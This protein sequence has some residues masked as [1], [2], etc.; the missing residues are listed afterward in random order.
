MSKSVLVSSMQCNARIGE[1]IVWK[2][3][4]WAVTTPKL[5][6]VSVLLFSPIHIEL[7]FDVEIVFMSWRSLSQRG[8]RFFWHSVVNCL[9]MMFCLWA[10]SVL[11]VNY[12]MRDAYLK[13]LIEKVF[14]SGCSYKYITESLLGILYGCCGAFYCIL[15]WYFCKLGWIELSYSWNF[16]FCTLLNYQ[17]K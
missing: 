6:N 16:D 9:A 10:Q 13:M 1:R 17:C 12:S 15:W 3:A 4:K 8:W 14:S 2:C 11:R 7:I 5:V